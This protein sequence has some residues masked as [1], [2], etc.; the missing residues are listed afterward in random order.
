MVAWTTSKHATMSKLNK[1]IT[2][3]YQFPNAD[4]LPVSALKP[5]ALHNRYSEDLGLR[6]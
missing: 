2:T 3:P 6:D 1:V 4:D 5:C